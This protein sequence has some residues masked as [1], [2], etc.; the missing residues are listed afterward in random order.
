MAS[1]SFNSSTPY[2]KEGQR[3]L[4]SKT[5]LYMFAFLM[6]TVAVSFGLSA[7][8]NTVGIDER[9]YTIMLI[10]ASISQLFLTI[11]IAI[12]SIRA[13]KASLI[14]MILYSICMGVLISSFGFVLNWWTLASA[15]GIAALAFGAMCL[16]GMF[17]KNAS[18]MGLVGFG[19]LI[20]VL[21]ASLFNV[22][23]VILMPEVW[24]I[25]NI[26][27]SIIIVVA[28]MLIT[29]YDVWQIKAVSA[30]FAGEGNLAIY[31]AFNLYLDFIIIL[32]HILRLIVVL[33]SDNR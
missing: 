17:A 18:G 25:Q 31:L 19:L 33:S 22:I 4:L 20:S 2:T 7:I 28:I 15:F 21:F 14:P 6:V 5:F 11:F 12:T 24:A 30:R 3:S 8:L 23:F 27:T 26:V 29:A 16:I 1:Y 32:L 9:A 10:V 13:G